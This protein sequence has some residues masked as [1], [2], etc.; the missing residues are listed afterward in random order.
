MEPRILQ[1]LIH[2]HCWA[3]IQTIRME[4]Q[5]CYN[6]Y[7]NIGDITTYK[8]LAI[9]PTILLEH[10]LHSCSFFLFSL[11]VSEFQE[12]VKHF[13]QRSAN[14]LSDSTVDNLLNMLKDKLFP[15]SS[16]KSK[17]KYREIRSEIIVFT[18]IVAN[19]VNEHDYYWCLAW[20]LQGCI[21]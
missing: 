14:G 15:W 1:E 10:C 13:P 8:C 7:V 6:S 21:Q 20:A 4:N 11:V 17:L 5:L 18:A 19:L 12:H 16:V 2:S 9:T 3:V